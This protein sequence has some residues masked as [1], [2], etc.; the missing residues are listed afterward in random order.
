[1]R[2]IAKCRA[3]KGRSQQQKPY[4]GHF[5]QDHCPHF[6]AR[7]GM[8]GFG[9]AV[10]DLLTERHL[11]NARREINH[12]AGQDHV[13]TYRQQHSEGGCQPAK[14]ILRIFGDDRP[15]KNHL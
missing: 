9:K 5:D 8:K 7:C 15:P 6:S 11:T 13:T 2:Q 1:M 14:G 3:E 4:R 12:R 10:R